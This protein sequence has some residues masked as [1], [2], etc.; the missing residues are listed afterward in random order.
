MENIKFSIIIPVYNAEIYIGD[1]IDSIIRQYYKHWE[2]I[3]IDDGSVDSSRHI[4][5][6]YEIQDNRIH[7]YSKTNGGASSARNYGLKYITG[8]YLIF[9]DADDLVLPYWLYEFYICIKKTNSDMCFQDFSFISNGCQI[10]G[11]VSKP[12]SSYSFFESAVLESTFDKKWINFSATW[13]KCFKTKIIIEHE[14]KFKTN[15]NL[16]E[17]FIFTSECINYSHTFSYIE[18][19]G[20]LYRNVEN[21]LSRKQIKNK[22]YI[23]NTVINYLF[24]IKP[25]GNVLA[26]N[27]LFLKQIISDTSFSELPY[28]QQIGILQIARKYKLSIPYKRFFLFNFLTKYS[29]SAKI[30]YLY[31]LCINK[32]KD[33]V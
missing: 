9:V 32:I 6:K 2:L 33:N 28:K 26:C 20:Y 5:E 31:I 14:I 25:F 24:K 18:Y 21:S 30:L 22:S 11:N 1:C 4:C 12:N 29:V 10:I 27:R 13:S 7:L 3:L 17:D 23:L 16:Y 15:L 19:K 8:D